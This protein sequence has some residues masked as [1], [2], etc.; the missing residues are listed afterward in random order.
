MK[1]KEPLTAKIRNQLS[2]MCHL[3]YL[4][5]EERT[6][7]INEEMIELCRDSE[8]KIIAIIEAMEEENRK[9]V[10]N[11]TQYEDFNIMQKLFGKH[12]FSFWFLVGMITYLIVTA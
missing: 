11:I 7:L 1:D 9:K 12:Y 3:I 5:E 8:I 10:I 2:P 6:D 4:H